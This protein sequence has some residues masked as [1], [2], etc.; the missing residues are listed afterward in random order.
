MPFVRIS[1]PKAFSQETKDK[2]S[3]SV[4][5]S[6]MQEFHIPENDYFHIIEE[7]GPQQIKYPET[8]L[9]INHTS[10]IVYIQIIA[11]QGR[12]LDQ[13]RALYKEIANQIASSTTVTKNNIIIAL[14][15][16]D[17]SQKWSFGDGMLQEPTHL[18]V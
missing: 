5:H 13:K 2:I 18:K 14:L 1:L 4:H 15:D 12:T 6:L 16:N 17:G 11:G 8:Y 10:D 7:L 9:G 3:K